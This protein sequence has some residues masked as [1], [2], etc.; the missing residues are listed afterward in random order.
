V[1]QLAFELKTGSSFEQK[2]IPL[3]KPSARPRRANPIATPHHALSGWHSFTEFLFELGRG[4]L[5][6]LF[7]LLGMLLTLTLWLLPVGIPLALLGCA[8]IA[9]PKD[10]I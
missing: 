9:T 5:G 8:L 10:K 3:L 1:A 7:L 6:T 4:L 2:F